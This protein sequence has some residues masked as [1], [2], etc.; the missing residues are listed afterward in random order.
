M[1]LVRK[2]RPP[3]AGTLYAMKVLKKAKI[4][5]SDKDTAHIK[6]ERNILGNIFYGQMPHRNVIG[7]FLGLIKHPFIVNLHYAFQTR[8]NLF[9]ILEYIQG[10]ELFM[11]LER[12]GILPEDKSAMYL[13]QIV[14]ALGHLHS[15]GK[16]MS[17]VSKHFKT[18]I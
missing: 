14:L 9:L 12:E 11:M 16:S 18:Y 4:I 1:Y 3:N 8:G 15:L 6:S 17:R 2:A 10:G 7:F 13:A 5:S